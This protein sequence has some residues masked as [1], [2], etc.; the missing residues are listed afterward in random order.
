MCIEWCAHAQTT[1]SHLTVQRMV[2][3]TDIAILSSIGDFLRRFITFIILNRNPLMPMYLGY[4]PG[5][6]DEI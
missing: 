1:A 5:K 2:V 6:M 3:S 4:A